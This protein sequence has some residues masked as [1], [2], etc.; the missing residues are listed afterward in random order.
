[1]HREKIAQLLADNGENLT[2]DLVFNLLNSDLEDA[3]GHKINWGKIVNPTDK[4]ADL[5]QRYLDDATSGDGPNGELIWQTVLHQT[6]DLVRDVYV[7]LTFEERKRFDGK[8]SS[9]F[10]THAAVQPSFNA[11]KL[12]A[13]M[14]IGL[15]EVVKLGNEYHLKKNETPGVCIDLQR[16]PGH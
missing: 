12:L 1:M 15:V 10:F 2:L 8:Y 11:E 4:P 3:Y 6:F 14:K 16:H 7:N 9:V 5:L 13:L